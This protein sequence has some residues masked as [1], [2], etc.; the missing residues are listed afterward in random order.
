MQF[1]GDK[2]CGCEEQHQRTHVGT[3]QTH[4]TRL[5]GQHALS[6]RPDILHDH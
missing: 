4:L 6:R 1:S 3:L 5:Y 2:G